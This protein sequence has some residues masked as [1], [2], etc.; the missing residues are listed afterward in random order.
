MSRRARGYAA[1]HV[2]LTVGRDILRGAIAPGDPVPTEAEL[3]QRFD[4]SKVIVRQALHRLAAAGLIRVRQGDVSRAL[5]PRAAVS[6]GV[7]E[8]Y[9]HVAPRTDAAREL[10]RHV[11]EKQYTQGLSVLDVFV[12]RARS[13]AKVALAVAAQ[14]FT[15]LADET[16]FAAAEEAFWRAAAAGGGNRVLETEVRWWYEVLPERPR[17]ADVPPLVLRAAFYRELARRLVEADDAVGYYARTL[18]PT[19]T[20][21]F[22][23]EAASA[24][25]QKASE[26]PTPRARPR[27]ER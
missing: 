4:I 22:A 14:A 3:S 11:L 21:L 20:A 27:R 25:P 1:D 23:D 10:V 8:L 7:I 13:E 5:D 2:F 15:D 24:T 6:L 17:R 12:R 18:G 16:A 19:M 9:Y 26:R